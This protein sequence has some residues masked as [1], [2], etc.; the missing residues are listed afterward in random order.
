MELQLLFTAKG[1]SEK[2]MRKKCIFILIILTCYLSIGISC[3]AEEK[4]I[5]LRKTFEENGYI[6]SWFLETPDTIYVSINDYEIEFKNKSN[7]IVVDE[8][9]F[10]LDFDTYIENGVT[11]ISSDSVELCAN[12]YLYHN[13]IIDA[14]KAEED[15]LL[16][17]KKIDTDSE[18]I[19]VCTWNRYPDT[20][21]DG[22]EITLEY[23]D[24][25]VFTADEIKNWGEK[26]GMSDNMTL[27][28]EQLI[29]LPPQKGYTHIY[30][31]CVSQND[32]FIP[33]KIDTDTTT[34][35]F[36]NDT[37]EEYKKWFESNANYSYNPHKYPWTG[38][39]Y[40]YDW[41]DNG[42]D[43]GLSEFI[44]KNGAKVKVHKT[45]SNEEFFEYITTPTL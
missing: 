23:G 3:L 1:R 30:L 4:Y 8:G 31:Q 7:V 35:D 2:T 25:W 5:P 17:L 27:R 37:T 22:S 29:G 13:A 38:L 26:N 36:P 45:Y 33:A 40:T 16:P 41:A 19:L 18:R 11:Y 32:F 10:T 6:V 9:E 39:G 15:E 28:M 43:Y 21:K 24:V 44:I 12:L 34:L 20:Y 42:T 14:T